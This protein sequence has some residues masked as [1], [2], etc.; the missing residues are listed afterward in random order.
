MNNKIKLFNN[1]IEMGLRI[2]IILENIYPKSFDIEMINYFDYF[3]LHTKDIGGKNSIHP[4]LPNRF[5]ELSVK[6]DLIHSSLKL[7][8]SK[9]LVEINYTD[10]GIEYLASELTSPFLDYLS[11]EYT[12]SSTNF[13]FGAA[14]GVKLL[15]RNGFVGEV[16]LGLGRLFGESIA[17]AYPRVGISLGKR[18]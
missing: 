12:R 16:Y 10:N 5:G 1:E 7:L 6:R 11:E 3:A 14:A 18:F 13:G 17:G 8:I 15:A 4:E 2:L 9:G